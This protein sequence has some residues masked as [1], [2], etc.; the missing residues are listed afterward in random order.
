MDVIWYKIWFDIWRNK[1]RTLLA[2]LSIAAGVFAVGAIFGMSDLLTVNLD[3]SHR[4]VLPTHINVILT[5]LVDETV[6]LH[7]RDIQGVEDVEPYN[8]VALQYKLKPDGAWRQAVV[9]MRRDYANQKYEI[10]QLR[11]G[12]WPHGKSEIAVERMAAQFLNLG[13]GDKV[14]FKINNK[15]RAFPIVGLI[16]HPFVPPPQ[17]MDLAFFFMNAEGMQRLDIPVNKYGAFYVR[18]TP[19]SADYAREIA[20]KIKDKLAKQNISVA[21]FLYEDPEKHWGRA[22]F[23][24]IV[25]VQELLAL[26]CVAISAVLIYNTLSNLITQQTNQIGVI[27]AIGGRTQT[28]IWIYL[29]SAFAYG[30]MALIISLPLGAIVASGMAQYF[31]GL[32]NID[33]T[34]FEVSRDAVIF[35]VASAILAPLL[36]GLPPTLQGARITVREA[37]ASYGLGGG[38]FGASRVDRLVENIGDRWLLS[39]YATSLGNMFRHKW[40][41]GMTQFVLVAAGSA[42][43]IVMSLNSSLAL[44]LDNYFARRHFDTTLQFEQNQRAGRVTALAQTVA[45]VEKVELHFVQSA[46][47]FVAGQ[48][49]KDAGVGI[50][51]E[52]IP[53]G[54]DFYSPLI[55]AGRWFAPNE[56]RAIVVNRDTAEKNNV[57]IGDVV[58]LDLGVLGKDKWKVVGLYDPVFVSTLLTGDT[59][60]A[61]QEELYRTTKKYNQGVILLVSAAQ[62][63][64]KF[65]TDLTARLKTKLEDS[66]LKVAQSITQPDSR[67]TNEWQFS[68]VTNMLI[69]LAIV[70]AIVGGIALMGA[71]SIAV[72]ERTKEIGVLRAVGAPSGVILRIFVM[73]GILQGVLSWLIAIPIASIASPIIAN[74][75]GQAMFGATLDYAYNWTSVFVWLG[76][77]V[78][79]AVF[80]SI[81]PARS[82]SKLTVRDTL[83]YE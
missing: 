16:R 54:S 46:S 21:V 36:A 42:F 19:Y 22:F 25:L 52:G 61:P 27:K 23:D 30:I 35:Q 69:A 72:I 17:F 8:S 10:L 40:R 24:G 51:I 68:T 11:S 9:Q 57:H 13:V 15:E 59:I 6:A 34:Q 4:A 60:Y 26:V 41:L 75:L 47:M 49:A 14:T 39:H 53:S 70:V 81:L 80:A 64:G 79:I 1:T 33:Y 73:E 7:I 55:V 77:V 2:V 66:G 62:R 65:V 78:V 28:I 5:S 74:S 12:I 67:Q 18:V 20:T 82:A 45:G 44:T 3:S 32:F 37:L 38:K 71:I 29:V 58:T 48:L 31:L 50:S 43:M 83:A 76:I 63:D 56:G